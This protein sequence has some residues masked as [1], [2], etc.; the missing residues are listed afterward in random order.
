MVP[1]FVGIIRRKQMNLEKVDEFKAFIS[2]SFYKI[3]V[4][5]LFLASIFSVLNC[6]KASNTSKILRNDST[7]ASMYWL[8]LIEK[9]GVNYE[10]EGSTL[11]GEAIKAGRVDLVNALIKDKADVNR[12][13]LYDSTY[14][15]T[16]GIPPLALASGTGAVNHYLLGTNISPEESS[17][18]TVL[19]IKAG[20]DVRIDYFDVLISALKSLDEAVFDIALPKYDNKMLDFSFYGKKENDAGL[21]PFS[22]VQNDMQFE[23]QKPMLENLMKKKIQ[24][25]FYDIQKAIEMYLNPNFYTYG[26]IFLYKVLTYM[27]NQKN[28]NV[29][30]EKSNYSHDN[31]PQLVNPFDIAITSI[32]RMPIGKDI[33]STLPGEYIDLVELFGKQGLQATPYEWSIGSSSSSG[34]LP[35]FLRIIAS[36]IAQEIKHRNPENYSFLGE[37][38]NA[39]VYAGWTPENIIEAF[40]ILSEYGALYHSLD[41]SPRDRKLNYAYPLDYFYGQ[42][43]EISNRGRLPYDDLFEPYYSVFEWLEKNGFISNGAKEFLAYEDGLSMRDFFSSY[44]IRIRDRNTVSNDRYDQYGTTISAIESMAKS[45]GVFSNFILPEAREIIAGTRKGFSND[46]RGL[47][48]SKGF[49]SNLKY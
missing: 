6:G 34:T 47:L 35:M 7:E 28:I 2:G 27:A 17:M 16:V 8:T 15:V 1:A 48:M 29:L 9:N 13:A 12:P 41:D 19:L 38:Q 26:D 46:V 30:T 39:E 36:K 11:L 40:E 3:L 33:F 45:D 21:T 43:L 22:A 18:M 14:G 37:E 32:Y 42:I 20:A 25:G 10:W 4:G 24:F 23:D 31:N 44:D 49:S 5:T